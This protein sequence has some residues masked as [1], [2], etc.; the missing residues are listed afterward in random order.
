M[1]IVPGSIPLYKIGISAVDI[2]LMDIVPCA[3]IQG[4]TG[5]RVVDLPIFEIV[6]FTAD[7]RQSIGVFPQH[8]FYI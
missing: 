2:S 7:L 5:K 1:D 3:V 8:F 6:I 4:Q